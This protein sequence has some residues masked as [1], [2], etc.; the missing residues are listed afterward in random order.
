MAGGRTDAAKPRPYPM[1][2]RQA[3]LARSA[4]PTTRQGAEIR[5]LIGERT[6]RSRAPTSLSQYLLNHLRGDDADE[7]LVEALVLEE[8]LVVVDAEAI[9]DGR[10]EVA[11]VNGVL[12]DVVGEFVG[13]ATYI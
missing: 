7:F 4:N 10:V 1:Q 5:G 12:D 11:H 13:W 2:V 3:R 6:R 8:E 9:K